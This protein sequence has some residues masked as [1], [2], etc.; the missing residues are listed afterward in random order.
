MYY[1]SYYDTIGGDWTMSAL[2]G[3]VVDE[4]GEP[5]IQYKPQS[6]DFSDVVSQPIKLDERDVLA[7]P[8]IQRNLIENDLDTYLRESEYN[9]V[10][11]KHS[12]KVEWLAKK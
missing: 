7:L 5:L 9:D 12:K 10:Y 2:D 1:S 4:K 11:E 6:I 8:E 3:K